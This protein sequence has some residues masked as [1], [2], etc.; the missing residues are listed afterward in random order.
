MKSTIT[1]RLSLTLSKIMGVFIITAGLYGFCFVDG[2][3]ADALVMTSL[4]AGMIGFKT[5]LTR[6]VYTSVK[7]SEKEIKDAIKKQ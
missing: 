7:V 4:G 1:L 3:R 6:D 5:Y 2:A